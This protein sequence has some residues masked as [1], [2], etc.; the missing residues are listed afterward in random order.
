MMKKFTT[1]TL[2]VLLNILVYAVI[3]FLIYKVV[4][5]AF[6]FSYEVFGNT[7]ISQHNDTPVAI[8]IKDGYSSAD[9]AAVLKE[10]GIIKYKMAFTVRMAL[11][12]AE[13]EVVPGTYEVN[14]TM[15]MNDIIA[16]ITGSASESET[17]GS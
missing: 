8:D 14:E 1:G 4:L 7:T 15:S 13:D 11:E 3:I 12:G 10:N 6:D 16:M 17:T 9:I 2:S 5:F